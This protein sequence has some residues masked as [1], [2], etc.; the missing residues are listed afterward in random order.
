MSK[1]KRIITDS[2]SDSDY[3][4]TFPELSKCDSKIKN[5]FTIVQKAVQ[6]TEPNIIQILETDMLLSDKM[7]LFELYEIYVNSEDLTLSKLDLKKQINKKYS[8]SIS[9]YKKYQDLSESQK[10]SFENDLKNLESIEED[11]DFKYKILHLD[12]SLENK[13]VIYNEYKRMLEISGNDEEIPKLKTWLRNALSLPYNKMKTFDYN[14]KQLTN[15]LQKVWTRLNEE[16]YG[17]ERAKEQIMIFLNSRL[18]NPNMK[19][20]SIGL[21]GPPGCG[22]TT[23]V[24]LLAKLL[25]YPLE[26][27]SLGGIQSPSFLKGHQYTYI[28]AEPGELVKCLQRMGVKNGILFFDEYDKVSENKDVC[29][30]LLHI[31]DGVQNKKF[32]DNYLSGIDIDLSSLWFF[33][34]MNTRPLDDALADRIF[35]IDLDGYTQKDKIN[36]VRDYLLK[37]A[38]KNM[39][40]KTNSLKLTEDC[41]EYIIDTVS[42]R[43]DKGVRN[44]EH[45][46]NSICNKINF[47]L[48]HQ[49]IRGKMN[50]N[51]SFNLNKKINFPLILDKKSVEQFL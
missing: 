28:G 9:K 32:R 41:I 51:F 48:H 49:D 35:Y 34:S 17:M 23:I 8:Q 24:K 47:L 5:S 25:E 3:E 39:G 46:I 30:A 6:K 12:C 10:S 21:L 37:K 40:W 13:K 43:E 38:H 1:R 36:I 27:I 31:T 42:P 44:L 20:C 11:E 33:Y 14:K 19:K 50:F 16:L 15:L 26:Q 2:D 29:S 7:E 45:T 4:M 18:L 22:K